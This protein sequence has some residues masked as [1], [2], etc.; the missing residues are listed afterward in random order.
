MYCKVL[1]SGITVVA[2]SVSSSI[3]LPTTPT[4]ILS[5]KFLSES[6]TSLKGMLFS[7]ELHAAHALPNPPSGTINNLLK[8]FNELI[9]HPGTAH[10]R[11]VYHDEA[12]AWW[13]VHCWHSMFTQADLPDYVVVEM[14]AAHSPRKLK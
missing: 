6:P 3:L 12:L 9:S 5:L 10:L 13:K 2:V 8:L 11:T 4:P 7:F 1:S 14:M